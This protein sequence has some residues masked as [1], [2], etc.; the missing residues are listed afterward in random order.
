MSRKR[1]NHPLALTDRA[2]RAWA[3][4]DAV[5]FPAATL[6][7][8]ILGFHEMFYGNETHGFILILGAI[9][10]IL[11]DRIDRKLKQDHENTLF[12]LKALNDLCDVVQS[13]TRCI[14]SINRVT[15]AS[16]KG[17]TT[18]IKN[19]THWLKASAPDPTPL[20]NP[21]ESAP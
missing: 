4:V 16:I 12:I 19:F 17:N 11:I 10:G 21:E 1:K 18:I 6:L 8:W 5:L 13:H 14:D 2:R 3:R 9:M 7:V 20:K 15:D